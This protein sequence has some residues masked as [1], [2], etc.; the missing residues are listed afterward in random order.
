VIFVL[1]FSL[2]TWFLFFWE[3][4][5]LQLME[6]AVVIQ[7][8]KEDE[9][10]IKEVLPAAVGAYKAKMRTESIDVQLDKEFLPPGQAKA[11]TGASWCGLHSSI[12]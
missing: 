7:Y 2:L 1:S 11:G 10:L 9:A 6:T 12:C 3:Q 4:G 8:R 5:L